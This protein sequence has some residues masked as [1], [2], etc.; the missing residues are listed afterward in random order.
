MM[1]MESSEYW[2]IFLRMASML[3]AAA[4]H[5]ATAPRIGFIPS[6]RPAATPARLVW[7]SASP[8][9][10]R[11]FSTITMPM[12]GTVAASRMPTRKARRINS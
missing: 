12:Q 11:R 10:E 5:T 1:A 8:I 9:I 3:S 4:M 2:G 7:D 6:T